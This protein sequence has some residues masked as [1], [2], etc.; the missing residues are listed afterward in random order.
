MP[1][2]FEIVGHA[3]SIQTKYQFVAVPKP[4][5]NGLLSIQAMDQ[6]PQ[7]SLVVSA[8]TI[9]ELIS[10]GQINRDTYHPVSA[11]GNNCWLLISNRGDEKIGVASLAK[12]KRLVMGSIGNGSISHL[13]GLMLQKKYNFEFENIPFRSTG[14][15]TIL[16]VGENGINLAVD[17]PQNYK[18]FKIK[19]PKVQALGNF[20]P[21]PDPHLPNIKPLIAQGIN[22][23][24]IF[25]T[26]LA[27]GAMPE[28]RRRELGKILDDSLKS[29][30]S[31][32]IAEKCSYMVPALQ[33]LNIND[34]YWENYNKYLITRNRFA[35][36]LEAAK[37]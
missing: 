18:N 22:A 15:A 12:E 26:F 16:L 25:N 35:K 17:T 27:N 11:L 28:E 3:N 30:G 33:G 7:N 4:G 34:W 8:S 29:I 32:E 24:L 1:F 9:V 2:L 21:V 23:P 20:C 31:K 14:E 13:T 19:N 36:Q 10:N 6:S 5:A 37:N